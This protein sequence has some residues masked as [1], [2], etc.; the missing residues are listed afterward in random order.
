MK[1]Q[2]IL[3]GIIIFHAF[4]LFSA[5]A[6]DQRI[7]EIRRIYN[8]IA[9]KIKL[10]AGGES[11]GGNTHSAIYQNIMPGT[12]YQNREIVFFHEDEQDLKGHPGDL[13]QT[14]RK[15]T[16]DY[17]IAA[18][19]FHSEYLFSREGHLLFHYTK[20]EGPSADER[21]F[22]FYDGE[23]IR[24]KID[25]PSTTP[26]ALETAAEIKQRAES[27]KEFFRCLLRY[28]FIE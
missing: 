28:Q 21:R 27:Y 15:V 4:G 19:R 14:L 23:L 10:E 26:P 17:N 6:E 9:E 7:L 18:V 20:Q 16:V 1:R 24:A 2:L 12:G 22:Y 3:F 25:P 11:A 13:V 5:S 8:E